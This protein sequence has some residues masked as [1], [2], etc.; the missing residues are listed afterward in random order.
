MDA[1]LDLDDLEAS[2]DSPGD[3]DNGFNIE[4]QEM[5]FE[6]AALK[7]A[8][9]GNKSSSDGENDEPDDNQVDELGRMMV[10]LQAARGG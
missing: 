6:F 7:S 2:I 1:F 9:A 8:L 4:G 5:G 3:D 10:H